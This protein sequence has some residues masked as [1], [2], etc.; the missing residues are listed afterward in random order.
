[1]RRIAGPAF[2][3]LPPGARRSIL[4][5]FGKYGPWED[6]FD[7]TPPQ[8]RK[9]EVTGPPDF[10]GIGTQKAGTTWWYDIICAHPDVYSRR[11]IHKE[12]HF[13]GRYAT[14]RFGPEECAL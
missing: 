4:H 8:A 13:F 10:V 14:R 7:P 3:R 1:L 2:A 6:G 11:D 12:R 9:D 5:A